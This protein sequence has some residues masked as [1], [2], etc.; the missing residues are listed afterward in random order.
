[1]L[2]AIVLINC[3]FPFDKQILEKFKSFSK[4]T[5]IYRTQGV[6]DLIVK[7]T[8]TSEEEFKEVMSEI[9]RVNKVNSTVTLTIGKQKQIVPVN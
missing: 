5:D 2:S 7:I 6:Y 1:M 8:T 9:S 3:H 4:I